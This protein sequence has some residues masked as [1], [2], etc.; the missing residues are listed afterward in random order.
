[1][2]AEGAGAV[3]DRPG[4]HSSLG[5]PKRLN[6]VMPWIN[7]PLVLAFTTVAM[8]VALAQDYTPSVF[9]RDP[10][11]IPLNLDDPTLDPWRQLRDPN[12]DPDREPGPFYPGRLLNSGVLAFFQLPIALTPEDLRAGEVDVAILGA[13]VDMGV[14]M[15]GAGT[16]P[17]ALRSSLGLLDGGSLPHM[18]VGVA[19]K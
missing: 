8:A 19:W 17:N 16:G 5:G 2:L 7:R 18:H 13:Q 3:P 4:N 10:T 9:D 11:R 15:R 1:V 14:G 12:N 6:C